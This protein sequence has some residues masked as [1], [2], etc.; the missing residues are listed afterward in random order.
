MVVESIVGRWLPAL[1][2]SLLI[3]GTTALCMG[4]G[5]DEA[6]EDVWRPNEHP[7]RVTRSLTAFTAPRR[8]VSVSSEVAARVLSVSVTE[9][10]RVAP[11]SAVG[12]QSPS[13]FAAVIEL[14][15]TLI[16]A[17]LRAEAARL[18]SAKARV[19]LEATALRQAT[20]NLEYWEDRFKRFQALSEEGRITEIELIDVLRSRDVAE[21]DR[22]SAEAALAVAK[23]GVE[24]V[25]ASTGVLAEEKRRH[26]IVAPVG[27]RVESRIAE[28][29]QLAQPGAPLLVLSDV[30]TLRARF[31]LSEEEVSALKEAPKIE[32]HRVRVGRT[33][34]ARFEF[35]ASS[36][37]SATRKR[38]VWLVIDAESSR[39][40]GRL[41][42]GEEVRLVLALESRS[43]GLLIPER[44]VTQRRGQWRVKDRTGR[45][46]TL[47]VLRREHGAFIVP[48]GTWSVETARAE[49]GPGEVVLVLPEESR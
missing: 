16:E 1:G 28:P 14:D 35:V 38:E 37:E 36:V 44:F 49:T 18:A 19:E 41:S 15:S 31:F 42:G 10:D 29:G 17:R 27:W 39:E 5:S 23:A 6:K 4:Q 20:R 7:A 9:G 43:A 3:C 32:L 46:H 26:R 40:G 47:G 8:S 25:R 22:Q 13:P 30:R 33:V 12:G 34:S 48:A 24:E 45:W 2:I 11:P 21:L